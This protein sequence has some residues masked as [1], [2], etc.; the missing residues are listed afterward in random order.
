M[1]FD[2]KFNSLAV[3]RFA[4]VFLLIKNF[5]KRFTFLANV[6]LV[7]KKL[8]L[9]QQGLTMNDLRTNATYCLT[10]LFSIET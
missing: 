9:V 6:H 2:E 5:F 8:S 3:F 4:L 1:F 7:F 10:K